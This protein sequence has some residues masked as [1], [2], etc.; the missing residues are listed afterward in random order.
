[1]FEKLCSNRL[2]IVLGPLALTAPLTSFLRF[3]DI[4]F[5]SSEAF[6]SFTVL[7]LIGLVA[8]LIMA[9]GGNLAQ[10]LISSVIIVL[11][12]F[13]E[14]NR[15]LLYPEG[16]RFRYVLLLSIFL[17]GTVLY[18]LRENRIRF[19]LIVFSVMWLMGSVSPSSGK[20]QVL[21]TVPQELGKTPQP[22]TSLPPYVHI[23]V[24]EHIGIEGIPSS[25]DENNKFSLE[26]KNK[27]ID[28]GFF[29][30]GRAYSRFRSTVRSF[31]NFLN[32]QSQVDSRANVIEGEKGVSFK[33]NALFET[34]TKRGYIINTYTTEDFFL[35]ENGKTYR[36]GKCVA[37]LGGG[38]K[39]HHGGSIILHNFVKKLRLFPLYA[40]VA[41]KLGI[42]EI[43]AIAYPGT[44][45]AV[46]SANKFIDFL[47]EGKRG[48]AYFIHLRLPH[49][50]YLFDENCLYNFDGNFFKKEGMTEIYARY[51][52]QIQCTHLIVDKIINKLDSKQESKDSTIVIHADHGSRIYEKPDET[53]LFTSEE[54]IQGFSAFF[55]IRSPAL[56]P[57][58]DRRPFALDELL[59]VSALSKPD[60][61]AL[62]NKK[63]KFVYTI[64]HG[65][66]SNRFDTFEKFTLPP[67]ANGSRVQKW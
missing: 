57:G 66:A 47:S 6:Y 61:M 35:C 33:P 20:I 38:L 42:P 55:V 41:P 46:D 34:L 50:P 64:P 16:I 3:Y 24:D 31:S 40:A 17:V 9:L 14:A 37:V 26:L 49:S 59:K 65:T 30:F 21:E 27:Y 25:Y 63:E 67:F 53:A 29:V 12:I 10:A 7:I 44:P 23:V 43:N 56:T 62:D 51:I 52:K 60:F 4:S 28:Q 8:G 2:Y 58:Y 48:N 11:F 39:H 36:M 32:F 5:L 54:Y 45:K 1:V 15:A 22:D 18:F 19:L 13:S